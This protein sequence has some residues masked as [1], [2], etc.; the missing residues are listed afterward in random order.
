MVLVV[1]VVVAIVVVVDVIFF[2]V[3]FFV[4]VVV[5][6]LLSLVDCYIVD[7]LVFH[8][9]FASWFFFGSGFTVDLLLSYTEHMRLDTTNRITKPKTA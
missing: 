7:Y 3:I 4:V 2:A 9:L 6:L 1:L 5:I 8:F